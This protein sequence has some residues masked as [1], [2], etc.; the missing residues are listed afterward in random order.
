MKA[1]IAHII[2]E[3]KNHILFTAFGAATG[4]VIM[5]AMTI[6]NVPAAMS[7]TAFYILHPLHIILSALTTT[8]IYKLHN[9]SKLWVIILIGYTGAIGIA[10]L[11]DAIIPYAGAY[12]IGMKIPFNI[13]FM[14]QLW[15]TPLAFIGI[16]IGCLKPTTKLPHAAHVLLSTWASLFYITQHQTIIASWMFL[17]IFLFLFLSVWL[18]C[19]VSDIVYPLVFSKNK[20]P[21][22]RHH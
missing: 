21:L 5:V 13:P 9:R 20:E 2:R 6:L 19:C 15:I 3:L 4:I 14:E 10:T 16:T 22:I 11:S 18:P 17:F 1:K 7:H 8:A 12:L